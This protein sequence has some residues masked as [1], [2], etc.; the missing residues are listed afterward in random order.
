MKTEHRL[1]HAPY[2]ARC[3]VYHGAEYE[4]ITDEELRELNVGWVPDW[5]TRRR[6]RR[7]GKVKE[8]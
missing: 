3:D 4:C 6:P 5:S 2:C 8:K 7:P 1:S